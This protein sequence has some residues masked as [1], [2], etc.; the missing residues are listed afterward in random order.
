MV[1]TQRILKCSIL[2]FRT[3]FLNTVYTVT[4]CPLVAEILQP[5]DMPWYFI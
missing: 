3:F 5:E 4:L 2:T 1:G